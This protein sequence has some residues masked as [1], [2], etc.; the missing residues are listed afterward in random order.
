MKYIM[1]TERLRLRRWKQADLLPFALIN[2][3]KE[4]CEF[5]PKRLTTEESNQLAARFIEHFDVCGFGPCA[6]EE[7][8]THT[9]IGYVGLMIPTFE[10][11][12]MPA[13]EIGWRLSPDVW[14]NGYATEAAKAVLGYGFDAL[15]FKEIVSFTVPHNQR[16]IRVMEKIGM[17]H[18]VADDFDHPALSDGHPLKHH[19][20]YR[21]EK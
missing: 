6:V 12:F 5:L 18:N 14:G 3:S 15:K 21:I 19:V 4:A 11:P 9:F 17:T 20:L 7:K 1:E 8:S 10:A 16:S 2:H 13:V